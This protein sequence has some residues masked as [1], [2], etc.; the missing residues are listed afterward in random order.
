MH[1]L[2]VLATGRLHAVGTAPDVVP[3]GYGVRPMPD[4]AVYGVT[5]EWDEATADWVPAAPI[6]VPHMT[7]GE[8][9]RRLGVARETYVNAVRRN[10]ATPLSVAA[11][12]DTFAAWLGR[13]SEVVV[14]D[15]VTIAGVGSLAALLDAGNQLPEGIPAFTA[16]MLALREVPRV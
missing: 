16:A 14:T 8:F 15:P 5:H 12:L 2:Y 6:M 11:E 4:G 10:P 7:P 3:P 13:V 9:A 1:G